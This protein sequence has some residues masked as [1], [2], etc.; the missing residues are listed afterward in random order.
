M[1]ILLTGGSGLLGR[2]LLQHDAGLIAP[3]RGEMDVVDAAS[4]ARAIAH[5]D[6]EVI[7]HCAAATRPLAHGENPELGLTVNIVGTANVCRASIEAAKRLVYTSTDYVYAGP[8]PHA[9]DEAVAASYNF[10]WSKL[11]GE[12][13]VRLVPD[14][15]ILRLSFGPVPFP[16]DRVYDDQRNSKLYVDEIAPLV[17]AAARSRSQGVM[18]LGGPA[19]TLAEYA[20]RTR[21]GILTM[22]TPGWVPRDTSLR[23]DRMKRE[24]GI[25]DERAVLRHEPQ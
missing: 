5:Y 9:E 20:R 19:A 12:C 11:G 10:G 17:L 13:A 1:R 25:L 21:P 8:G 7:L 14:H 22:A 4:V 24:L 2:Q 18:N 15:L 3:S 6:P 16:W 23:L